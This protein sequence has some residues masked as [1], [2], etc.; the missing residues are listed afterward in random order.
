MKHPVAGTLLWLIATAVHVQSAWPAEQAYPARPVRLVIPYPPGGA[1]DV[2]GREISRQ[3]SE[4]W[5]QPVVVDNRTGAA[6]TI[7][8]AVVAKANPDGYTLVVGTFGGLVSGPALM[9]SQ[10]PY[11]PVRDFTP[12]GLA[13][14][15]PW[16]LVLHPSV[17]AK[18]VRELI[19]LAKSSPG[20]LNYGSTGSGTP[21]HLGM[22]L[23]LVHAGIDIVHV[24]YRGA[25]SAT[26]DL[27]TGRV[28]ALFSGAP[29]I[30][31]HVK[32]GKLRAIGVGHSERLNALP[33]VPTIAETVPG[34]YNS[35]YYGLL[36]PRGTPEPLVQ[37]IN[38][39]LKAAFS[40][41]EVVK[42]M[43]SQGLIAAPGTPAQFG[44]LIAKD[45]ALWRKVIKSTGITAESAQ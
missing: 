4:K 45:L 32:S 23:L 27:L 44:Q 5:G 9:G 1:T 39:D 37:R 10:V 25:G 35:G 18:N 7:G 24:P 30:I 11:Y 21:N 28:H 20:K 17:A 22:V 2:T 36:G 38:A 12:I 33:D 29:Q 40:H 42:R 8:H 13:V 19:E 15:T 16:V 41:P 26:L 43:E 6:G 31:P 34:F 14:H 3:L